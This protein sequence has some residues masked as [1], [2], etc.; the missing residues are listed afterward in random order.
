M[1]EKW[2]LNILRCPNGMLVVADDRGEQVAK[3]QGKAE[4]AIPRISRWLI[5][6]E[7]EALELENMYWYYG[8]AAMILTVLGVAFLDIAWT[9]IYCL[10][11]GGMFW[12]VHLHSMYI[13]GIGEGY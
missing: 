6:R 4:W 2:E 7:R 5:Y 11:I 12:M 13:L 9:S 3:L 8:L 1:G 10:I